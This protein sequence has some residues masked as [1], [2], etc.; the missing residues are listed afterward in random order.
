MKILLYKLHFFAKN[1]YLKFTEIIANFI[2]ST[3]G[4][5]LSAF[6]FEITLSLTRFSNVQ[7]SLPSFSRI[8]IIPLA[9]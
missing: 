8:S 6:S 9:A 2:Y 7:D 4:H 1:K 5:K 3:Y